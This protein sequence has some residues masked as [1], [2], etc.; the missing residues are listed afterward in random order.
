MFLVS[1]RL[2]MVIEIL[3]YFLRVFGSKDWENMRVSGFLL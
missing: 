3:L 2:G 1:L